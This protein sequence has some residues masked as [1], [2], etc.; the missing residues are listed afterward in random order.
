MIGPSAR[1]EPVITPALLLV[2]FAGAALLALGVLGLWG[3]FAPVQ[4]VLGE[5]SVAW[6]CLAAGAVLVG[7]FAFAVVR[8]AA[9]RGRQPPQ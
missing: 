9:A 3:D 4:R 2:D 7:Y 1:R 5:R 8:R 6:A